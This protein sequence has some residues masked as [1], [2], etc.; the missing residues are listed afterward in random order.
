M[1]LT[2][3]LAAAGVAAALT[4]FGSWKSGRPRK[5]SVQGNWISWPMVTI[6]AGAALLLSVVHAI[7]LMGI[8]TGRDQ[9]GGPPTP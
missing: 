4:A 6:L 2:L 8:H 1:E 5:D 9:I 3:T 7:N